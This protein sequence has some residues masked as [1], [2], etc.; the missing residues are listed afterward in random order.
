MNVTNNYIILKTTLPIQLKKFHQIIYI[1]IQICIYI[2]I[3]IYICI[4]VTDK[5]IILKTKLP[6]RLKISSDYSYIY[7][8]MY[9][10]IKMCTKIRICINE[11][12]MISKD[13]GKD[14]IQMNNINTITHIQKKH[15]YNRR[16]DDD[17]VYLRLQH[18][19]GFYNLVYMFYV[20]H[21]NSSNKA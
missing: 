13:I 18:G 11:Y 1:Y 20:K 9:T 2:Y 15:N 5:Y 17:D 3:R 6:I 14:K 19:K 16:Y 4:N 12:I 10:H 7:S 21:I 8:N